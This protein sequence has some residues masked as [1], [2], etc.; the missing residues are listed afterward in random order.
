[1]FD[2][3]KPCKDCPFIKDG[4]MIRSLGEGRMD[5]IKESLLNDLSFPCHK[6]VD[7]EHGSREKEQ[8][9]AGAMIWLYKQDRPNQIMRIAERLGHLSCEQLKGYDKVID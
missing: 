8:H 1:M 7:Y 6:T 4:T 2:L 3:K 5:E 9:C